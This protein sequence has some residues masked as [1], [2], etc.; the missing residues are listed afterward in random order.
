MYGNVIGKTII[1]NNKDWPKT[2]LLVMSIVPLT[3]NITC[4]ILSQRV[5]INYNKNNNTLK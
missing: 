4:C 1:P 5:T 2:K 3:E